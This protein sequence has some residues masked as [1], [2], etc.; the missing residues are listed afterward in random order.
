[1]CERERVDNRCARLRHILCVYKCIEFKRVSLRM[2]N[3][4]LTLNIKLLNAGSRRKMH[5]DLMFSFLSRMHI[6][7]HHHDE[8]TYNVCRSNYRLYS[9]RINFC[10]SLLFLRFILIRR[11]DHKMSSLKRFYLLTL[12]LLQKRYRIYIGMLYG[13]IQAAHRS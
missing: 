9:I 7:P 12:L 10:F 3:M 5:F 4:R 13:S 2:G 1:M 11:T 6:L 8:H